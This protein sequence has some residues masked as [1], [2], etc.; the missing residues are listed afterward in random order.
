MAQS[1]LEL[2]VARGGDGYDDKTHALATMA[3]AVSFET[4]FDRHKCRADCLLRYFCRR[5][6][7]KPPTASATAKYLLVAD[8][9]WQLSGAAVGNPPRC[10][11]TAR[12]EVSTKLAMALGCPWQFPGLG[13][14]A[15]EGAPDTRHFQ[16]RIDKFPLARICQAPTHSFGRHVWNPVTVCLT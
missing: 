9:R 3:L 7:K 11:A 10:F 13:F 14:D 8:I 5:S 15:H 4:C 6:I 2:D 12:S 1:L 16:D